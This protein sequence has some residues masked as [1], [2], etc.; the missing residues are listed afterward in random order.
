MFLSSLLPEQ[1]NVAAICM[2]LHC[3]TDYKLHKD[4]LKYMEELKRLYANTA[5]FYIS[6][7]HFC[8]G[9]F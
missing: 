5:P 2:H 8:T 7:L 6:D 9:R 4:N 3:I 1:D